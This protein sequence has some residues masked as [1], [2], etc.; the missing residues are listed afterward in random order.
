MKLKFLI[1]SKE[2]FDK[3]DPS[4][5]KLYDEDGSGRWVLSVEGAVP[6]KQLDDFR[7]T[8]IELRK[9]VEA[10][11]DITPDEA[12]ELRAKKSEFEAGND[13]TKIEELVEKRTAA[14]KKA[15]EDE[16]TALK[17][18]TERLTGQL[19]EH[20][21]DR[22]LIDAGTAAGLRATAADDLVARGRKLFR[23]GQDGKSLEAVDGE[24]NPIYGPGGD[25]LNPKDWIAKLTKEAAHL[26]EPSGGGG[27]AGGGKGGQGGGS[28]KNPWAKDSWNLTAQGQMIRENKEQART[29]AAAAGVNLAVG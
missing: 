4:I 25:K 15:H 11:G 21:I 1:S 8:N 29:M 9:Q 17:Q 6:K 14:M 28:G 22:A 26:F 5:Q 13:K 23:V 7:A 12:K 20:V 24:G 10:F 27:A 3:L 2:D 19:S 18:S 16:V